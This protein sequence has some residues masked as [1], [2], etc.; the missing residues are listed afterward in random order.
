MCENCNDEQMKIFQSV[1]GKWYLRV[2]GSGWDYYSDCFEYTD[3][4]IE[5]C[6]YCGRKLD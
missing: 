3:L 1:S 5:Y 2:E 4:L 6:P